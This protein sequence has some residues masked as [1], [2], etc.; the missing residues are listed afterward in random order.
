LTRINELFEEIL[1]N[2]TIVILQYDNPNL[3]NY[4]QSKGAGH[5]YPTQQVSAEFLGGCI[6]SGIS[7]DTLNGAG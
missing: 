5:V 4:H 1:L 3:S 7:C 2:C 6:D